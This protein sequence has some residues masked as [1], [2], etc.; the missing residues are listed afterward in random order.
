MS[1]ITVSG[2]NPVDCGFADFQFQGNARLGHTGGRQAM[3]FGL[4]FHRNR[5]STPIFASDL[6]FS[7][8][9]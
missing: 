8:A 3:H 1:L 6:G 2:Q 4:L 5:L 7:D 9:F